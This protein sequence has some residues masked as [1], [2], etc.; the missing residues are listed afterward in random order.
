MCFATGQTARASKTFFSR[1]D[2]QLAYG[3]QNVRL[4]AELKPAFMISHFFSK[5]A[6]RPDKQLIY[7]KQN[8][9]PYVEFKL[10]SPSTYIP[11]FIIVRV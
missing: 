9:R 8:V 11:N 1:L 4:S 10:A 5:G 2:K 3:E 7:G 6:S